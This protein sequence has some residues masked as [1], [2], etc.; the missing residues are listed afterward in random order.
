[1]RRVEAEVPRDAATVCCECFAAF[2]ADGGRE[3]VRFLPFLRLFFDTANRIP[4]C[5]LTKSVS[6]SIIIAI[7]RVKCNKKFG[8]QTNCGKPAVVCGLSVVI[9]QR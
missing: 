6:D 8:K 7:Q 2:P 4:P 9:K 1:M 3:A 5:I